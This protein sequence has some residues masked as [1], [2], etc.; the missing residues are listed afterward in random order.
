[1]KAQGVRFGRKK[2][3]TPNQRRESLARREAGERCRDWVELQ[4]EPF[5]EIEARH[6]PW[7]TVSV[8]KKKP[9]AQSLPPLC[10]KSPM[11]LRHA[12]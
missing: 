8:Q 5:N 2:R 1:M 7:V 11:L 6:G 12:L 9:K 10:S 3:L 4:R